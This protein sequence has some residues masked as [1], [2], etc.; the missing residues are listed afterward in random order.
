MLTNGKWDDFIEGL[1]RLD[2]LSLCQIMC[3]LFYPPS[4]HRTMNYYLEDEY[5]EGWDN[6]M[7]LEQLNK[8]LS[9]LG[10]YINEGG[11]H[12]GLS[13]CEPNEASAKYMTRLQATLDDLHMER[14]AGQGTL[15][16][17]AT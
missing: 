8:R 3:S 10:R 4:V 11:R 9:A 1:R 6:N 13:D 17:P 14:L 15:Q 12:P 7:G 2:T 16:E 5:H